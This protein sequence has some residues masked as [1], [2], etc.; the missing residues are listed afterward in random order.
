MERARDIDFTALRR[1]VVNGI[2]ILTGSREAFAAFADTAFIGD[3]CFV[4]G[5]GTVHELIRIRTFEV[6]IGRAT[7]SV[8][9][10]CER[11]MVTGDTCAC[12]T[13]IIVARVIACIVDVLIG[14]IMGSDDIAVGA[15]GDLGILT[16]CAVDCFIALRTF[17]HAIDAL[18]VITARQFGIEAGG[19]T[20]KDGIL[21]G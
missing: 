7:V 9:R 14:T 8:A 2:I 13:D 1:A 4:F 18:L 5:T 21:F 3:A 10:G 11:L 17:T 15:D 16:L 20:R 19:F 6:V 12:T